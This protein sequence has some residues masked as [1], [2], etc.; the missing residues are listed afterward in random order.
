MGRRGARI[1]LLGLGSLFLGVGAYIFIDQREFE[2]KAQKTVGTV[3]RVDKERRTSSSGGRTRTSITYRPTVEYEVGGKKYTFISNTTSSSY[4]FKRGHELDVLYD[5]RNP[6][7]ARLAGSVLSLIAMI[8]GGI[9][10]LALIIGFFL[11]P[12][13]KAAKKYES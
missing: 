9:G 3:L 7:D 11:P 6:A 5:P 12:L 8:F 13:I 10:A 4:N 1:L 2:E